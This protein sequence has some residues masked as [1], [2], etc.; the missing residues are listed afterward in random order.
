[1]AGARG[2]RVDDLFFLD[3][4]A[5][6]N[7]TEEGL[8]RRVSNDL[9]ALLG[10]TVKSLTEGAASGD[11]ANSLFNDLNESHD[12]TYT[13]TAGVITSV[14]AHA[15]GVP[16]TKIRE[17]DQLTVNAQGLLNGC[18]IRQYGD[19]GSTVL[20]TLTFNGTGWVKS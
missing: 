15:P 12:I 11:D 7:P 4:T 8:V 2:E 18:R 14:L 1:M 19:D 20:E 5:A 17:I 16:A 9:V 6:G 13:E 3:Q 10:G